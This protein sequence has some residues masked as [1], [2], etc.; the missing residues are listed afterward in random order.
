[1]ADVFEDE[2]QE[3]TVG[4]L[5][6][7]SVANLVT[8]LDTASKSNVLIELWPTLTIK[9]ALDANLNIVHTKYVKP[10]I[11]EILRTFGARHYDVKCNVISKKTIEIIIIRCRE[12]NYSV[13]LKPR[14]IYLS[15]VRFELFE[16]GL[17][18]YIRHKLRDDDDVA[19]RET[20]VVRFFD[21]NHKTFISMLLSTPVEE[22]MR[23]YWKR[24]SRS[25]EELYQNGFL[26]N[27]NAIGS[28]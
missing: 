28:L 11:Q 26:M 20:R 16:N 14:I 13:G 6:S 17:Y 5:F 19:V 18:E 7:T 12:R 4:S 2:D 8:Q 22:M 9:E 24:K 25:N 27:V 3:K 1:M 10:R 15:I 21:N 23:M